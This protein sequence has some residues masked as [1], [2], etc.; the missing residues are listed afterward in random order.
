[1]G[2]GAQRKTLEERA[3]KKGIGS[4]VKF[5]GAVPYLEIPYYYHLADVVVVPSLWPEPFGRVSAEALLAGRPVLINPVGGLK[6]QVIDGLTG[7][8]ANCYNIKAF[9]RKIIEIS[10]M[11]RAILHEM[12]LKA[13]E[14]I[15]TNF[16]R[17]KRIERLIKIYESLR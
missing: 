17:R 11:P 6:E 3:E 2:E 16:E 8:H 7:F 15:L 9:A 14:H 12:G 13:R 4:R 1:M 5:L 10:S